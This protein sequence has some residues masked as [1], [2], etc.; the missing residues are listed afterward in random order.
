[1]SKQTNEAAPAWCLGVDG[2]EAGGGQSWVGMVNIAEARKVCL[3]SAPTIK[4]TGVA[5]FFSLR[6]SWVCR[7]WSLRAKARPVAGN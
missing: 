1:M 3:A 4:D 7:T 2:V 5:A 6:S